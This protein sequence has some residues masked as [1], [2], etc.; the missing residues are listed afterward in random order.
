VTSGI[1][2]V[3]ESFKWVFLRDLVKVENS[4][5]N[6]VVF[7]VDTACRGASES[8]PRVVKTQPQAVSSVF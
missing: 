5:F 8:V 4:N 1:L 7:L 2:A 6:M 3:E